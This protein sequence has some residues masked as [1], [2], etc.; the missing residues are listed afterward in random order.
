MGLPSVSTPPVSFRVDR[1]GGH[2]TEIVD[3]RAD[4]PAFHVFFVPGNPGV[5]AYYKDFLEALFDHL[6]GQASVT[7]ISHI[8]H[9][10]KD[11]EL[12]RL[13]TL[14]DQIK[15]K[16]GSLLQDDRDPLGY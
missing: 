14:Q 10:S 15:H 16:A 5:V 2:A 6:A 3:L 12:G 13:F 11:W 1:I 7:A 4:K 8:A 9:V